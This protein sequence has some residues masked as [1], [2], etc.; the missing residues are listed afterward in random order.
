MGKSESNL[1]R[2]ALFGGSFNPPHFGHLSLARLACEQNNLDCVVFIPSGNPP[3]KIRDLAPARQRYAMTKIAIAGHARFTISPIELRRKGK[4]YTYRTIINWRRAYPQAETLFLLGSDSLLEISS[5]K[6]G[7]KLFR[8]CS[9][10]VGIRENFP[11]EKLKKEWLEKVEVLE[12]KIPDISSTL[13]RRLIR[14]NK[15][16]DEFLPKTVIDYIQKYNLYRNTD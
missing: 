12:G 9:F 2:I 16:V 6:G 11:A 14:E 13:I 4:S 5:W 3:H 7:E 1:Q 8:L 15:P 10:I